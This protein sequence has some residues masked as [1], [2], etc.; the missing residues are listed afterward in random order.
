MMWGG[1]GS[2]LLLVTPN[3]VWFANQDQHSS[4][5]ESAV[6]GYPHDIKGEGVY[7]YVVLKDHCSSAK[8]IEAELKSLVRNKIAAYAL[9]DVIQVPTFFFYYIYSNRT[10]PYALYIT[11]I[12]FQIWSFN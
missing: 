9:P 4:V 1:G 2:S 8:E 10:F 3:I 7:A 6:V 12:F 5:A 11:R